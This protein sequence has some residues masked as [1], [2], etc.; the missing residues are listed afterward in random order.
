MSR[1][2]APGS[3]AA[4][5]AALLAL[6]A[7]GGPSTED[8]SPTASTEST[9]VGNESTAPPSA[10]QSTDV[11]GLVSDAE[12]Q[13]ATGFALHGRK[14]WPGESPGCDWEL[15]GDPPGLHKL[16]LNLRYRDGRKRFDF[17][18]QS[19]P[20]VPDLG[21]AAAKTGGDING[22][23]WA[24]KGQTLATLNYSLPVGTSDPD[25]VVVPLMRLVLSRQ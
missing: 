2:I 5:I 4:M 18:T 15:A 10:L 23:V 11:C 13:Q 1:R 16:S 20:A 14:S 6:A 12:F 21:D 3:M 22:T 24:V 8:K 9:A 19:L 17:V 7:C 25:A